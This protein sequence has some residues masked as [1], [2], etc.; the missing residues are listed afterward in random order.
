[1]LGK[2]KNNHNFFEKKRVLLIL[3]LG[4]FI[5]FLGFVM[6]NEVSHS[7]SQLENGIFGSGG[8]FSFK[9]DVLFKKLSLGAP[10]LQ[11]F[12]FSFSPAIGTL[13]FG[14]PSGKKVRFESVSGTVDLYVKSLVIG[15]KLDVSYKIQVND[16]LS[17]QRLGASPNTLNIRDFSTVGCVAG[18]YVLF[19]GNQ[20]KC[21]S[22]G[23]GGMDL[24]FVKGTIL[25]NDFG[26]AWFKGCSVRP[27]VF[28]VTNSELVGK[29]NV[30]V[31]VI[32][33]NFRGSQTDDKDLKEIGVKPAEIGFNSAQGRVT[34]KMWTCF[35]D[36]DSTSGN[37]DEYT[38]PHIDYVV[39]GW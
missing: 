28:T 29:S 24:V 32:G 8:Y 26:Y 15:K 27:T 10:S 19:D 12:V 36:K 37:E 4:L 13:D 7:L 20:W 6:G 33:F 2:M 34:F 31:S 17:V 1:M 35:S 38:I 39:N 3:F 5:L 14:I 22:F 30:N 18:D 23:E 11:S 25:W 16:L 21:Y 9:N